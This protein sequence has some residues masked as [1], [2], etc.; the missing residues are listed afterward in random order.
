MSLREQVFGTECRVVASK[1]QHDLMLVAVCPKC[2][3]WTVEESLQDQ[4]YA[5]I[6]RRLKTLMCHSCSFRKF[7]IHD[8]CTVR[9]MTLEIFKRGDP[10]KRSV[11]VGKNPIKLYRLRFG[12]DNYA[13]LARVF[14]SK[15]AVS[16]RDVSLRVKRAVLAR[17]ALIKVRNIAR[18]RM[19]LSPVTDS[20]VPDICRLE[21]KLHRAH[22]KIKTSVCDSSKDILASCWLWHIG[23]RVLANRI[24]SFPSI[25][26]L[27][28][29]GQKKVGDK[30]NKRMLF[31]LMATCRTVEE[32]LEI[33]DFVSGESLQEC[34]GV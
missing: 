24:C 12:V 9:D 18:Y 31:D 28:E 20:G 7:Q 10:T 23:E 21:N 13:L 17:D 4:S 34:C 6:S 3:R 2:F 25:E 19:G 30:M 14:D 5:G 26:I 11:V 27:T 1:N 33:E 8:A 32:Q 29:L 16:T 15:H 22:K